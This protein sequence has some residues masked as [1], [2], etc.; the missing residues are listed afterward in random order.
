MK[1]WRIICVATGAELSAVAALAAVLGLGGA[2][3]PWLDVLN[4]FAPIWLF[5]ALIGLV[6]TL[7]FATAESGRA[8]VLAV[9]GFGVAASLVMI[10]PD[11][12][13]S[14]ADELRPRLGPPVLRLVTFNVWKDNVDVPSTVGTILAADPDV[15]ALQE[16]QGHIRAGNAAL[17]Q[18]LPYRIPCPGADLAIYTRRPPI[19]SGCEYVRRFVGARQAFVA[20]LWAR[21]TARD[22]QPATVMTMHLPWP[23]P[24]GPQQIETR[25]AVEVLGRFDP[26]D[27]VLAGDFNTAPWSFAMRNRDKSFRPLTRRTHGIFTWPARLGWRPA[28]FAFLPIDQVYTGPGWRSASIERLPLAGSDHFGLSVSLYRSA[29]GH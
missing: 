10:L 14:I 11:M 28:P 5:T 22:G 19:A 25:G 27:L 7:V 12:L 29:S 8:A 21:V 16:A 6:L 23:V 4:Q 3:N 20:A 17:L 1:L 13:R 9:A 2:F 18:V 24:P 15:V 26:H